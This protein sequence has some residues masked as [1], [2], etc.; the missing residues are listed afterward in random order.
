MDYMSDG[1]IITFYRQAADPRKQIGILAELNATTKETITWI[2]KRAG[3][4]CSANPVPRK[5]PPQLQRPV[6]P[7]T[8]LSDKSKKE[9]Q[10]K[11]GKG[12]KMSPERHQQ[13]L[14][15]YN[16]GLTDKQIAWK[17]GLKSSSSVCIWRNKHGLSANG[18]PGGN[19]W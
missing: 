3:A 15:L 2:L 18:K 9:V 6:T 8:P 1:E 10:H 12:K 19:R 14:N 16:E 7:C 13:L 4:L 11:G 17:V 5:S